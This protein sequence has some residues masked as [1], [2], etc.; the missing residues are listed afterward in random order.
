MKLPNWLATLHVTPH[1]TTVQH[2]TLQQ[3][4]HTPPMKYRTVPCYLVYRTIPHDTQDF[5]PGT[6]GDRATLE[7]VETQGPVRLQLQLCLVPGVI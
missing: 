2:V 6:E 5:V 4:Y 1:F 7:T 3:A